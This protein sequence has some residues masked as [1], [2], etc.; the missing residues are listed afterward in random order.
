MQLTAYRTKEA[1]D[2][3]IEKDQGVAFRGH[4]EQTMAT[5]SDAYSTDTFPFRSHLGASVIGKECARAVWYGWRWAVKP[6]FSGQMLRLFNRGHLEE[7]RVVAGLLTAGVTVWQ[8]DSNGNQFRVSDISGYFGGSGD[9]VVRG[10]PD[11]PG[12]PLLLEIKTHNDKR[13]AEVVKKGVEDAKFEHFVQMQ[14]YM[15]KMKLSH[16]LYFAVN[17]NN[18]DYYLEIVELN[19]ELAQLKINEAGELIA[20]DTPPPRLPNA[21]P[22]Y[23]KCKFCD[24]GLI[25]HANKRPEINCRTCAHMR[26][27]GEGT[28]H[29][30]YKESRS[31]LDKHA[32]LKGCEH[33]LRLF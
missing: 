5:V 9:G 19:E 32:Q 27:S 33:H 26:L 4:L 16:A 6:S 24:Y 31:T 14:I 17:K 30:G 8:F 3:A 18:D 21:G 1:I 12:V 15:F 2:A 13:F 23:F 7:A 22:G 10:I 28:F 11:L 29:C 25:C 20:T